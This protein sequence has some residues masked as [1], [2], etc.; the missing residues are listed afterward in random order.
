MAN[1]QT[2]NFIKTELL[3]KTVGMEILIILMD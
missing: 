3:L 2:G 1:G